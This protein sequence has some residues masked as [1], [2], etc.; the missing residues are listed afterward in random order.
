MGGTAA[1]ITINLGPGANISKAGFGEDFR[2]LTDN[3]GL[4]LVDLR[5]QSG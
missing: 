4:G 5:R 2:A 3:D 1:S